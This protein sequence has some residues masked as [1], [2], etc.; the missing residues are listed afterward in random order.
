MSNER[1]L[2]YMCNWLAEPKEAVEIGIQEMY[3]TQQGI[4]ECCHLLDC[5]QLL[6]PLYAV[7]SQALD[8][9]YT[10]P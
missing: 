3:P 7:W 9:Q 1:D 4:A 8:N 6:W 2:I 5:C 10:H